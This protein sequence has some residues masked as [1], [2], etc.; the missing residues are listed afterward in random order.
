[1]QGQFICGSGCR[2]W[3]K[4]RK[5]HAEHIFSGMPPIADVSEPRRQFRIVPQNQIHQ[6]RQNQ[7]Q[8][9]MLH[10]ITSSAS[11]SRLSE[12][13]TPCAFAVFKLMTSSNL[14]GC[15]T[16]RSAGLAPLRIFAVYAPYWRYA[17]V[18]LTP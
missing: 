14:V 7:V 5:P 13:A 8:L 3:V 2:L 16:G 12:M 15:S 11:E 6:V 10:S 1:M 18:I 17:S 4:L 9:R